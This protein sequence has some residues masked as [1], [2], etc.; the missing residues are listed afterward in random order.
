[1]KNTKEINSLIEKIAEY[2]KKY[3][4]NLIFKGLLLGSGLVL[5]SYIFIN[6]LEFFGRFGSTFRA[7]LLVTFL[8]VAAY[9][10][11]FLILKPIFFLLKINEP[12]TDIKAANQIGQFFPTIKDK[13]LNTLQLAILI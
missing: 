10:L 4:K 9:T 3:Y 8:M 5:G 12:L 7:V 1:M 11:F 13:L 6:F 2:K